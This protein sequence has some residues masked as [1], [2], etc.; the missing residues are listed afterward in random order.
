MLT[1]HWRG[2][3]ENGKDEEIEKRRGGREQECGNGE[4][5]RGDNRDFQ[6]GNEKNRKEMEA[7]SFHPVFG[8]I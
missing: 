1:V 7:G 3:S 6:N 2:R 4:G 5:E 8:Q